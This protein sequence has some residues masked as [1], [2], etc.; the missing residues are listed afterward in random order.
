MAD[1]KSFTFD[2]AT[3]M[4]PISADKPSGE[5]LRDE[6]TYDRIAESR[7]EDDPNLVLGVWSREL[8]RADWSSV[9]EICLEAL[10]TRTKDLQVAAWLLESWI[11]LHG[12]PGLRAGC[13]LMLELCRNFWDSLYPSLGDPDYRMGPIH[14]INEKLFTKLKF[15]PIT[16]P[17][18]GDSSLIFSFA[19]WESAFRAEQTK[20]LSQTKPSAPVITLEVIQQGAGLTSDEFF[21][22]AIEDISAAGA[23]CAQ[24]EAIF[25]EAFGQS[26]CSLGQFREVLESIMGLVTS[27]K[28][29]TTMPATE[30]Y[31]DSGTE[32][33]TAEPGA[34]EAASSGQLEPIRSRAE[35][36]RR[37]AEIADYLIRAEP[38]SPAPYLIRR[39]ISWGGMTLEQLLPELVGNDAALKDLARLLKI[40]TV[41]ANGEARRT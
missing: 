41:A 4:S 15:I 37:L 28:R 34:G 17:E 8:K 24:L 22:S 13:Q 29:D 19:Q 39:A 2:V 30:T 21:E 11:H 38:H 5:L 33:E 27:F 3:L 20:H 1:L 14:W 35:A 7:R 12:F 18:N 31:E 32:P 25:D 9:S 10:E 23:A 16:S 26:S 36:Y 40:D 6:A